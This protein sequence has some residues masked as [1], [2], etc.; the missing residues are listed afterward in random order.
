MP[1]DMPRYAVAVHQIEERAPGGPVAT[2]RYD[3]EGNMLF[4][5]LGITHK[6]GDRFEVQSQQDWDFF[7]EAGAIVPAD[8]VGELGD[9]IA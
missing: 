2:G 9:L 5:H 6:P 3:A 8:Q 7:M 4:Q 1:T